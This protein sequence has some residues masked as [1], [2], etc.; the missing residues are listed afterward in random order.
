MEA[1]RIYSKENG[2]Y[3]CRALDLIK[4]SNQMILGEAA[5]CML[6][7]KERSQNGIKITGYG[8]AIEQLKSATSMSSQGLGFQKSMKQAIGKTSLE[9]IDGI[10]THAPGTIQGDQSEMAA[11]KEVFGK[12]Y[13]RLFNNKWQL[14]HSLGASA[15]VNIYMAMNLLKGKIIPSIPYL[16]DSFT[17]PRE[18]G[19][20][21]KRLLIN[22]SGFGGN[23][24]SILV[25]K[26]N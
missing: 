21:P 3:P 19:L 5:A 12:E 8:T 4:S 1:L 14:G 9:E 2:E 22:A 10:I 25:E 6:L 11:I 17:N 15:A 7:S 13:P 26:E 18:F 24:V 16:P 23:C 20:V